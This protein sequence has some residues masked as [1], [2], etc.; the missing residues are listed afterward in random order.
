M[1]EP[2]RCKVTPHG[3]HCL[4]R[5]TPVSDDEL[6][7]LRELHGAGLSCQQIGR[8][9]NRNA[10]TISRHA[11]VMGLSFDPSKVRAATEARVA[12]IAARRAEVSAQFLQI[13]GKINGTVLALLDDPDSGVKPWGLRDYAY[14]AS[15]YFD[16]HLSQVDHDTTSENSSE[17]DRWLEHMTGSPV[18]P[19]RSDA[20]DAAKSRSVLGALMN[21][22]VERHGPASGDG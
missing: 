16:R 17:V 11:A 13:V 20:D 8:E 15:A 1:P 21:D 9:M 7:R 19:S 18:P 6:A 5:A 4:A 12:D 3:Q 22:L 10:G 2:G 14:A